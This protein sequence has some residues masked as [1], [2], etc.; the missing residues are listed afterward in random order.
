[1]EYC[2]PFSNFH[3]PSRGPNRLRLDSGLDCFVSAL[4][5]LDHLQLWIDVEPRQ[6]YDGKATNQHRID[7]TIPFILRCVQTS[8]QFCRYLIEAH[9]FPEKLKLRSH[10]FIPVVSTSSSNLAC[11]WL[12]AIS[13]ILSI[14]SGIVIV[15][16]SGYLEWCSSLVVVRP[17]LKKIPAYKRF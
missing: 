10:Q 16:S 7:D 12:N 14:T 3:R 4:L 17:R 15:T 9:F 11:Q 1:M 8:N 2:R 5:F 13:W 6:N